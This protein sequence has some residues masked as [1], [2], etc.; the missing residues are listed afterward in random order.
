MSRPK[1]SNCKLFTSSQG[2]RF[3]DKCKF[4]HVIGAASSSRTSTPAVAKRIQP[5]SSRTSSAHH[6]RGQ[7]DHAPRGICDFYWKT[8]QCNRGFDCT[9]QHSQIPSVVKV[10]AQVDEDAA[11]IALDFFTADGFADVSGV[12]R[13]KDHDLKPA[14][15]HNSIKKYLHDD[16]TF[17]SPLNMLSFVTILASINRRNKSWVRFIS[18]DRHLNH[19]FSRCRAELGQ[20]SG[21]FQVC[22][23]YNSIVYQHSLTGVSRHDSSS[24]FHS[25]AA[26]TTY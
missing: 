25:L 10:T 7:A 20:C 14:D 22:H 12:A 21:A 9:F 6:P 8:G 5:D 13:H 26:Y 3:G 16:Y 2:C 19:L 11:N 15:A 23:N 24:M 17:A 18:S 1:A 4:S